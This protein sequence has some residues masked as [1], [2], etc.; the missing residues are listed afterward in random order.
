MTLNAQLGIKSIYEKLLNVGE[1]LVLMFPT[2]NVDEGQG[3]QKKAVFFKVTA[4]NFLYARVPQAS[5]A[6]AVTIG[7][8]PLTTSG[9]VA[10]GSSNPNIFDISDIDQFTIYHAALFTGQ[11][12][13]G[14]AIGIENP[15]AHNVD[16]F[17][18]TTVGLADL[19]SDF[20]WVPDTLAQIDNIATELTEQI[21]IYNV[22]SRLTIR[23]LGIAGVASSIIVQ[24]AGYTVMQII[25]EELQDR[26]IKGSFRNI[27]HFKTFGSLQEF[28]IE[29]PDAWTKA[30]ILTSN[31]LASITE[32]VTA[33]KEQP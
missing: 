13:S 22:V 3:Q 9:I 18:P 16:G 11:N 26:I 2:S 7:P 30:R 33:V 23:N 5:I 25:D 15:A 8:N 14:I 1:I 21:Y 6:S 4:K 28:T 27:T 31:E 20:G 29:L 10:A 17:R 32:I 24:G 19:T 12:N